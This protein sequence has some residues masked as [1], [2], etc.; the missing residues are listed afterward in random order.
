MLVVKEVTAATAM[1]RVAT[2]ETVGFMVGIVDGVLQGDPIKL[3]DKGRDLW[4][5]LILLIG[6]GCEVKS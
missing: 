6:Q 4:S 3:W 2:D 1:T 5:R